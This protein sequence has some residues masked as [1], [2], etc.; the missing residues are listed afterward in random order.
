M[1]TNRTIRVN[2]LLKRE[3]SDILHTRFQARSVRLTITEVRVAPDLRQ[4]LVFYSVIGGVEEEAVS[5]QFLS[6]EGGAIRQHLARRVVLKYLPHL[7]FRLDEG[8]GRAHDV[9]QLLDELEVPPE[10]DGEE[11]PK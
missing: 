10:P 2:E 4:A 5:A 8:P 1:A 7:E 3:I 9:L 11:E 6:A